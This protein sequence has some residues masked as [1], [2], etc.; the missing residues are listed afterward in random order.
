MMQTAMWLVVRIGGNGYRIGVP[1]GAARL[2]EKNQAI[3]PSRGGR[4]KGFD[5]L[6]PFRL[7]GVG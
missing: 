1:V 6:R 5:S 7:V 3:G 2:G 4:Q